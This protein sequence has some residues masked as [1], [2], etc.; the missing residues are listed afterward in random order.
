MDLGKLDV[1]LDYSSLGEF[2]CLG[3]GVSLL[4]KLIF[5]GAG[6]FGIS[7]VLVDQVGPLLLALLGSSLELLVG[8]AQLNNLIGLR[9]KHLGTVCGIT[10]GHIRRHVKMLDVEVAFLGRYF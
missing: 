6:C 9:F 5:V 4:V 3:V 2:E 1:G 10:T 7:H 8:R